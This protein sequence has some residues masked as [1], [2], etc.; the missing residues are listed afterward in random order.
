LLKGR[1][2]R[3]LA[4]LVAVLASAACAPAATSAP[5]KTELHYAAA[6]DDGGVVQASSDDAAEEK[7]RERCP[8]GYT[9]VRAEAVPIGRIGAVHHGKATSREVVAN[10]YTYAC[11]RFLQASR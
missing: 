5:P 6:T 8:G 7:M 3:C 4:V 9:I 10:R 1:A 2:M 11:T